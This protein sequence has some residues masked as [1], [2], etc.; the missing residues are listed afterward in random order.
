MEDVL[1]E[2]LVSRLFP[3][4]VNT[5]KELKNKSN[6]IILTRE[7]CE[8][9]KSKPKSYQIILTREQCERAEILSNHLNRMRWYNIISLGIQRD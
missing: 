1:P 6:K 4:P 5:V 7:H 8:R 3:C 2:P 9:D